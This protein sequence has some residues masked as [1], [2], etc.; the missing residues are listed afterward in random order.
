MLHLAHHSF[1]SLSRTEIYSRF[2][3]LEASNFSQESLVARYYLF[4]SLQE[5]FETIPLLEKEPTGKPKSFLIGN[6]TYYYSISH[7]N[8]QVFI[9]YAD[10]EIG[11]DIEHMRERDISVFSLHANREYALL[12]GKNLENFYQLWTMKESIVKVSQATLD[13]VRDIVLISVELPRNDDVFLSP[14]MIGI[15]SF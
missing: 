2:P 8:D 14:D 4:A 9:A 5:K 13:D 7:T 11:I 1:D 6:E 12:G 3:F 15:L 10:F